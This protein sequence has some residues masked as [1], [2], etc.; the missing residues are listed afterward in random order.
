MK[1]LN[2]P[3]IKWHMQEL[4]KL[5][6]IDP[7]NPITVPLLIQIET[8]LNSNYLKQVKVEVPDITES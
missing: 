3:I 4:Q 1:M 7:N 8:M 5:L 2:L 6:I